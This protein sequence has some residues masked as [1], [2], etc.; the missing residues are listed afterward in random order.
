MTGFENWW[1]QQVAWG[2]NPEVINYSTSPD[3]IFI[4]TE[5]GSSENFGGYIGFSLEAEF[6]L[7]GNLIKAGVWE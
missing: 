7:D 1:R 5:S 4:C 2:F 6:D 3:S